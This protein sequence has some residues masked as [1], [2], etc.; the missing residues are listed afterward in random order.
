VLPTAVQADGEVHDT[1]NRAYPAL[2]EV[3]VGWM[4]QAWPFQRSAIVPAKFPEL[5]NTGPTA[6]QE[7]AEVHET[8]P[9]PLPAAP[10]GVGTCWTLHLVPSQRSARE[11]AG[12]FPTAVQ[13]AAEVHET[14]FKTYPWLWEVGVGWMR[15]TWPFQRSTFVPNG[16]PPSM[17]L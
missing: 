7:V 2:F 12:V 14:A 16:V 8:P 13:A 9:R 5:S 10:A 11:P 4:L 1:A 3:G 15:H 6:V 17:A